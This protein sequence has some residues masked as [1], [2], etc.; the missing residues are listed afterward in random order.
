MCTT[1]NV[2]GLTQ[3]KGWRGLVPLHSTRA[4]VERLLGTPKESRGVA[5]TYDTNNERVRAFYS[6]GKCNEVTSNGWNVPRDTLLSFTVQPNATLLVEDLKL[7]KK[8]ERVVDYHVHGVVYYFNKED[9]VRISARML[10]EAGEDVDSITYEPTAE[11]SNLK[12]APSSEQR[13]DGIEKEYFIRKF[14]NY[15][16]LSPEEEK[17]RLDNFAIYLQKDEPQFK[18]YIVVYAGEGARSGDAKAHA[19]WAK[20]HLIKVRKITATRIITIDGGCRDRLEVEL[21]ALPSSMSPP[22]P[23]P[24]CNR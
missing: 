20:G 10:K 7:D 3:A 9:G 1:L 14:D 15:T 12:C 5:S 23:N 19:K 21:Y 6:G 17:A 11:D 18:G 24:Y 8:Y 13:K 22:A 16:D 4:D 2:V